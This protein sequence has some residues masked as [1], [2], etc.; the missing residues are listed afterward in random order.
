MERKRLYGL[1]LFCLI[2]TSLFV[3]LVSAQTP[4][5]AIFDPIKDLFANWNKGELSVNI[6]KYVFWGI[7]GLLIYSILSIISFLKD[8]ESVKII[9]AVLI[10]FLS[11]A[12]LTPSDIY[13]MLVAYGALGIV[14]GAVIPYM[15]LLFFS[16]EM[17]KQGGVGGKI[18]SKFIWFAFILFLIYKLINGMYFQT[19]GISYWEGWTY[20]GFIIF[21]ILYMLIFEK[22]LI[23]GIFKAEVSDYSEGMKTQTINNIMADL[24]AMNKTLPHMDKS[25]QQYLKSV[26]E[27]NKLVNTLKKLGG[28]WEYW[29]G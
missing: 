21:V 19:P 16:I 22:W 3:G 5:S 20:L 26:K 23:K 1:V 17:S 12:Y 11:I 7:L 25:S 28:S 6:A 29:S 4:A 9:L 8:N 14:M 18:L 10:S 2:F 13:T 27:Y 24:E 15:I